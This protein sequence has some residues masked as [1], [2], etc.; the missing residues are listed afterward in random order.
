MT[1]A[2]KKDYP[3]VVY[4]GP[5]QA[6]QKPAVGPWTERIT[7]RVKDLEFKGAA[8]RSFDEMRSVF[9]SGST[10]RGVGL[11][12]IGS[13]GVGATMAADAIFRSTSNGEDRSGWTRLGEGLLGAGMVAGGILSGGRVR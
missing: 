5:E 1:D 2:P 4:Q 9:K 11:A 8:S 7:G 13:I 10:T 12:R 6:P 3:V